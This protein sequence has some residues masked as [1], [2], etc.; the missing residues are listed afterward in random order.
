[1]EKTKRYLVFFVGLFINSLGVSLIT[2]AELGTSPISSIPY[3]LSLKF[4]MTLGGFTILFS[5][6][7]IFFAAADFAPE[8]SAGTPASGARVHRLW[9]FY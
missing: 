2:K 7:L 3:V 8:F 5:L 4:P 1:M 6:L 9:I